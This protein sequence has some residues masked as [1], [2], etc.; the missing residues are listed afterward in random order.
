MGALWLAGGRGATVGHSFPRYG[1]RERGRGRDVRERER[2]ERE[3]EMCALHC[4]GFFLSFF[5]LFAFFFFL[6]LWGISPPL[7]LF[8]YSLFLHL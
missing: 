6:L 8:F 4:G 2:C 1:G 3:G 5:R 7:V